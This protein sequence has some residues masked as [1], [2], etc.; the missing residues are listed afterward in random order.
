MTSAGSPLAGTKDVQPS[1]AIA[2]E[3]NLGSLSYG[4]R[5]RAQTQSSRYHA[6]TSADPMV[7]RR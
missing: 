2:V 7:Q 5:A 4:S 1:H 6:L 3:S